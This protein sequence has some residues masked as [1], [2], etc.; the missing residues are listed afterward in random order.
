[1]QLRVVLGFLLSFCRIHGTQIAESHVCSVIFANLYAP[2]VWS[3]MTALPTAME[4][5]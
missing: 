5:Q 4:Y 3:A 2:S 1:M